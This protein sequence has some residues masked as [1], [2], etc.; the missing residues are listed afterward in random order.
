LLLMVASIAAGLWLRKWLGEKS[1]VKDQAVDLNLGAK[2]RV[3]LTATIAVQVNEL[4]TRLHGLDEQILAGTVGLSLQE[5]GRATEAKGEQA[6]LMNVVTLSEKLTQRL[7]PWYVRYKEVIASAVAV[8]GAMSGLLAA[9]T[10]LLNL[11]KH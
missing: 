4:V 8:L 2:A 1:A 11:H 6:A 3:D 5:Y 9:I 7:S 10:S